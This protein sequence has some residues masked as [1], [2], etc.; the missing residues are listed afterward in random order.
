MTS[1]GILSRRGRRGDGDVDCIRNPTPVQ[2]RRLVE[3]VNALKA[4]EETIWRE[5]A[6][7]A[8]LGWRR[9]GE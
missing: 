4:F 1:D 7:D 6:R 9:E 8:Q 2:N 3:S 5:G